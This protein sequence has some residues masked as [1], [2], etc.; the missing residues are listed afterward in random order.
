MGRLLPGIDH[1]IDRV[2]GIAEG[3]RLVRP[4]AERDARLPARRDARRARAARRRLVLT[5]ETSSRS[6]RTGFVT[7]KGRAKRFAKV[8]RRD[9]AARRRRG[10]SSPRCG[11]PRRTRSSTVPDAKR[12]EQIVLVTDHQEANRG[13]RCER[14]AGGRP[15]RTVRSRAAVACVASVPVLARAR[16]ITSTSASSPRSWRK[17]V[18][19]EKP[20]RVDGRGRS[21]A[22]VDAGRNARYANERSARQSRRHARVADVHQAASDGH[23]PKRTACAWWA[24]CGGRTSSSSSCRL[25]SGPRLAAL[26]AAASS[27]SSGGQPGDACCRIPGRW[28]GGVDRSAQKP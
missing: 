20:T 8:R 9:G 26:A 3:G 7:I 22:A 2:E 27:T 19:A 16:S 24:S 5:P 21:I 10:T 17:R 1:R 23:S 18:L 11:R 4:R 12:G 15:A 13:A 25:S 6:T 28:R 14:R